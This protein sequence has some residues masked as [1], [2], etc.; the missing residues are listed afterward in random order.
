MKDKEFDDFVVIEKDEEN[1]IIEKETKKE[2]E[3]NNSENEN[4]KSIIISYPEN[5]KDDIYKDYCILTKAS[6]KRK[7]FKQRL[8]TA[9]N[10]NFDI[11]KN[12]ITGL[13]RVKT[14][15]TSK[16]KNGIQ[17]SDSSNF[18][19][20]ITSRYFDKKKKEYYQKNI[21]NNIV[22][23]DDNK[24][25]PSTPFK[26]ECILHDKNNNSF[27]GELNVDKKYKITFSLDK[28]N[29][30]ALYYNSDYYTFS[31]LSIKSYSSSYNYFGQINYCVEINL[32]DCR[33][34]LF[35]FPPSTYKLFLEILDKYVNPET[36][37]FFFNYSFLY[38]EKYLKSIA[39]SNTSINGWDIYNFE[40]E[41]KRQKIDF[42][43][44]FYIINNSDFSFCQSYP[45]KIIVP[46]INT[47]SI[48][49]DLKICADFRTKKRLP[50]LAYRH[51]ND[52]CLWRCSQT[53]NGFM[54][55]NEKDVILLTK[56]ADKKKL[57]IYDCR[58]K[59]NAWA[60]KLKGAGYENTLNYPNISIDILFCGIPNIHAVRSSF[61]KL[62][63]NISYN[64]DYEYSV[65]SYLPD[66]FWYETVILI[67]KS[68]FQI[69]NSINKDKHT[70]LIH[71]SDGWDRTSQLSSTSQIL[72]DKYYRTLEGFIV[73]IEKEWLSFG[74]QFRYRNKFYS[75]IDTP[76]EISSENQ[77]SPIF[78]QWLDCLY[79][80]MSQNYTKFEF[81]YKLL[82]FLAN[83]VYEGK[84]GTFLFNNDYE[85]EKYKAKKKTIS[86]WTRVLEKKNHFLN[87][88]YDENNTDEININYKKIKLW[89]EYFY[90]YEK[91][92]N[93]ELYNGL[94]TRKIDDYKRIISKKNKI[95]KEIEK[96]ISKNSLINKDELK[97]ILNDN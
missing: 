94:F 53:R 12:K 86:I 28:N 80:I 49:N 27:K 31:F 44:K 67:L 55:K 73:L 61:E 87:P 41:F 57:M 82:T 24:I 50:I 39:H 79:Q 36:S 19:E 54:G 21:N 78:I 65:I 14:N 17:R 20:I 81:N 2:K 38:H 51:N 69:Y 75:L 72:L 35:K 59:L 45:K 1:Y 37:I 66:T 58:P 3:K 9:Y 46:N 40:K 11:T 10:L 56:I 4:A 23:I 52:V 63:S 48:D 97:N 47:I 30:K 6:N 62:F 18:D 32:K 95:I 93:E 85:R 15:I 74:H 33:Y 91:G 64:N 43:N 70:V 84:Y 7:K 76:T 88:I 26:S 92:E 22:I 29:N 5:D 60:N 77:F 13:K 68:S 8:K 90:K 89:K 25:Q 96:L 71:C 34:F 83:E 16:N 42:K